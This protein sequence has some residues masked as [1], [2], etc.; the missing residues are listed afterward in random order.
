[1]PKR[2]Y[3]HDTP[4]TIIDLTKFESTTLS[5]NDLLSSHAMKLVDTDSIVF[6]AVHSGAGHIK[7]HKQQ[8]IKQLMSDICNKSIKQSDIISCVTN[9]IKLFE[10][11]ELVNAGIGSTLD[12]NKQ[13]CMDACIS[14]YNVNTNHTEWCGI[15]NAQHIQSP[16]HVVQS[17]LYDR[18]NN[19]QQL[20][21]ERIKPIL[22]CGHDVVEYAR[23]KLGDTAI[24]T[25][26]ISDQLKYKWLKYTQLIK[27]YQNKYNSNEHYIDQ[28]MNSTAIPQTSTVGCIAVD[29][30]GN[31]C[32][33]SSSGGI[34]M[35]LPG[36]VG[37]S[38]IS[39]ASAYVSGN[40]NMINKNLVQ[41]CDTQIYGACIS[42][43][44]EDLLSCNASQSICQ[45]LHTL[46]HQPSHQHKF[47]INTILPYG[48]IYIDVNV[49]D[50]KINIKLNIDSTAD[51]FGV[52]WQCNEQM[53][54]GSTNQSYCN[55]I[56]TDKIQ[57]S[58]I[59][60]GSY[61]VVNNG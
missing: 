27:S 5:Y 52:A 33:G 7:S 44:G 57:C 40:N 25:N 6:V 34:W 11:S 36:R 16:I 32:C 55:S 21:G 43:C 51:Q 59:Y 19:N 18:L 1:M 12:C 41:P 26:T 13:Q 39:T 53:V 20:S 2:K 50:T 37:H 58:N 42:G 22:L 31:I 46:N 17:M 56:I 24:R 23:H 4:T 47:N 61:D 60:S 35:K 45:Q 30:A 29:S 14:Y 28:S 54:H 38:A 9:A 15:G 3:N 10:C 48:C 49:S 8:L